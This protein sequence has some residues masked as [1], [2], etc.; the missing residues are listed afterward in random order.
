M[1]SSSRTAADTAASIR[2]ASVSIRFS[3]IRSSPSDGCFSGTYTKVIEKQRIEYTIDDGRKVVVIF[4]PVGNDVKV[5]V[6]FEAED[7]NDPEFQ[8]EGWQRILN[9]FASYVESRK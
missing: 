3:E 4:S 8:R 6:T 1:S 2:A 7:Q 9:N 5:E